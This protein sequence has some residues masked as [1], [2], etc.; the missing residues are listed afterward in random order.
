MAFLLDK[1]EGKWN[2]KY[3]L[4]KKKRRLDIILGYKRVIEKI[5]TAGVKYEKFKI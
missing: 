5:D 4:K 2:M 1:S 3:I